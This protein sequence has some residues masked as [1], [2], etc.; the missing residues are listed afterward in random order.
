[1]R[2]ECNSEHWGKLYLQWKGSGLTQRKFCQQLGIAY[3]QFRY[4]HTTRNKGNS[5]VAGHEFIQLSEIPDYVL[6]GPD[7]TKEQTGIT[8]KIGRIAEL[9]IHANTDQK[10][11]LNLLEALTACGQM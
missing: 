6:T 11:L 10:A 5:Q 7:T 2:K 3:H 4:Y 1:M 9:T 8:L